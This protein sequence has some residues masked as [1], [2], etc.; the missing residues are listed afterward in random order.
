MITNMCYCV[1]RVCPAHYVHIGVFD[2]G[3]AVGLM[4]AYTINWFFGWFSAI[5]NL[6]IPSYIVTHL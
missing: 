3:V 4:I 1:A 2:A 6:Q 5:D